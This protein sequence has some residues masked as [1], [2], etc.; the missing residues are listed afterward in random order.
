MLAVKENPTK[1]LQYQNLM[2]TA[3]KNNTLHDIIQT[4]EISG[5]MLDGFFVKN[6][7]VT[8][9]FELKYWRTTE[10]NQK[11]INA[12]VWF[13][14]DYK[15][16]AMQNTSKYFAVPCYLFAGFGN[17]IYV[18]IVCNN[19]G[20]VNFPLYK[21]EITMPNTTMGSEKTMVTR[22]IFEFSISNHIK[23]INI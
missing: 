7:I 5:A 1:S 17:V 11:R 15:V 22:N 16:E 23:K 14:D 3:I 8:S 6:G 19:K 4:P 12:G 9:F 2:L 10:N 21:K 13:L 20:I 18:F